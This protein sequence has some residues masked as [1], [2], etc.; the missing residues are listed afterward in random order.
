[1]DQLL[2][3]LEEELEKVLHNESKRVKVKVVNKSNHSLPEYK[4]LGDSGMDVK[5]NIDEEITLKPLERCLVP[6]GLFFELPEDY[7]IQVRPRSGL[8][9]KYGLTVLNTPGTIKNKSL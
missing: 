8:A 5:A 3:E 6:T 2:V 1:M 7:E 9:A 4:H